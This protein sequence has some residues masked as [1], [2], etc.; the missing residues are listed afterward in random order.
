MVYEYTQKNRRENGMSLPWFRFYHEVKDD[1]KMADLSDCEFRVFVEAMCWACEADDLGST[2]LTEASVNWA[3]R[4]NVTVTFQSLLQ[5]QL[6]TV[7][8]DG[9]ICITNWMKRQ[10]PSDSST[11]RVRKLRAKRSVTLHETLLKRPC[12]VLEERRG[13]EKR[14][15]ESGTPTPTSEA[16]FPEAEVPSWEEFRDYCTSPACLLI[17]EWYVR[18]K[19]LRASS[20]NWKDCENWRYY[21]QRCKAWW[22]EAGRPMKPPQPKNDFQKPP[23]K[24]LLEKLADEL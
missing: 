15:E 20:K 3:F 24:T 6:F 2:G 1:P 21:A 9:K 8:E 14:V 11:A 22:Q 4:R 18:D 17:A 5:K 13:E 7:R 12:N 23:G 10:I 16:H 19:Y